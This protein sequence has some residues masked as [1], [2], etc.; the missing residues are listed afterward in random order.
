M[1]QTNDVRQS[2]ACAR[3]SAG[4]LPEM[5]PARPVRVEP[6]ATLTLRPLEAADRDAFLDVIRRSRERLAL[7]SP[8]HMPG[9]TDEQLFARQLRLTQDGER[10]GTARRRMAWADG[11]IVGAFNL[12]S[13]SRGLDWTADASCWVGAGEGGRGV[14]TR[15]L[16]LITQ[17]AM[18][19]LPDGLGLHLIRGYIQ[20]DNEAAIRLVERLGFQRQPEGRTRLQTGA[21][22]KLHDLWTLGR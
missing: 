3:T 7:F 21:E 17:H 11:R 8:L 16:R 5:A 12:V 15:A 1:R 18:D 19:D 4:A 13:I 10:T 6:P 14:A 20:R 9:E 2:T 22:W